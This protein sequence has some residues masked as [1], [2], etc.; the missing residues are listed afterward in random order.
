MY[1]ADFVTTTDGTGV[2]HIAPMYGADD[3]VLGTKEGLP[4]MHTVKEDGHFHDWC[5]FLAGRFAKEKDE[6]WMLHSL[7]LLLNFLLIN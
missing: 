4:K 1:S 5:G 6:K 7:R 2:V 3:F